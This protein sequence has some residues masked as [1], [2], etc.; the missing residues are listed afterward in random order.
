METKQKIL[1]YILDSKTFYT[2]E[3]REFAVF[4]FERLPGY[5]WDKPASSSG[6]YHP[7]DERGVA[8][9]SLHTYR[10]CR[11][12]N[13]LINAK[14]TVNIEAVRLGAL[15]HDSGRFGL[16]LRPEFHSVSNHAELGAKFLVGCIKDFPNVDLLSKDTLVIAEH[17][18]LTHMGR[19]GKPTP[20]TDED[21]LVHL[22]DMVAS[23]YW[24]EETP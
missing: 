1:D 23:G 20:S 17:S 10:V 12:A 21:W 19:W 16:G 24:E 7:P 22:A 13:L 6:K 18:I 4:A 14:N 3:L 15:L 8:G 2:P 9:L 5:F 11:V